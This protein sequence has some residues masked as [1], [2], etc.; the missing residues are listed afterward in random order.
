MSSSYHGWRKRNRSCTALGFSLLICCS[1]VLVDVS[2]GFT[3]GSSPST[4]LRRFALSQRRV[5]NRENDQRSTPFHHAACALSSK[6][7]GSD[8]DV[9]DENVVSLPRPEDGSSDPLS[10]TSSAAGSEQS[11]REVEFGDVMAAFGTSPR[12]IFLSFASAGAIA[13]G[14]DFC[15]VT[16]G[17][18][19]SLPED[20]A[21]STGL[22][23]YYPRGECRQTFLS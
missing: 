6:P 3:V 19:S 2:E 4:K 17:L 5:R 18:L 1:I 11:V 13:L 21:E 12:R 20:V 9:N 23:S 14:A 10:A 22:D 15:G 8:R 7:S 16:Q